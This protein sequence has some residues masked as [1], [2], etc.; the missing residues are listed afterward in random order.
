[1]EPL[2][3]RPQVNPELVPHWPA[4]A[5]VPP[6]LANAGVLPGLPFV[7]RERPGVDC[8]VRPGR[9]GEGFTYRI[10]CPACGRPHQV[11]HER[12][13]QWW[14]DFAAAR[15]DSDVIFLGRDL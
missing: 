12:A 3:D 4:D 11:R 9:S 15:R 10:T 13:A 8:V 2:A 1:M 6:R 14:R 5:P 7:L